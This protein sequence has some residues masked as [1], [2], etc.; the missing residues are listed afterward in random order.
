MYIYSHQNIFYL[1]CTSSTLSVRIISW[2]NVKN[3]TKALF[4]EG[5]NVTTVLDDR[6]S[7]VIPNDLRQDYL[8]NG[9]K[10][11]SSGYGYGM[12]F[13]KMPTEPLPLPQISIIFQNV[14]LRRKYFH[15][16]GKTVPRMLSSS[17]HSPMSMPLLLLCLLLTV[18]FVFQLNFFPRARGIFIS[19]SVTRLGHF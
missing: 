6:Y 2:V 9:Q 10:T 7:E 17:S 11:W 19:N 4:V 14:F 12:F 3:R 5:T 8:V 1:L 15:F 16:L 18:Y 13:N